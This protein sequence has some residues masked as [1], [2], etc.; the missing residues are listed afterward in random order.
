MKPFVQRVLKA[1]RPLQQRGL[2]FDG[3]LP[4]TASSPYVDASRRPHRMLLTALTALTAGGDAALNM[5]S[6]P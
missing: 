2:L 1:Y 5:R 4:A 3:R 6:G